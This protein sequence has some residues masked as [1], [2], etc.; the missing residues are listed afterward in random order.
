[1]C[2]MSRKKKDK[3]CVISRI[4]RNLVN[5]ISLLP[6]LKTLTLTILDTTQ[7][8][9]IPHKDSSSFQAVAN[10]MLR[11]NLTSDLQYNLNVKKML[12]LVMHSISFILLITDFLCNFLY[13]CALSWVFCRQY[14]IEAFLLSSVA[15]A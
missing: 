8:L 6:Q 4:I 10:K 13:F 1:M 3:I 7:R 2:L 5:I 14:S 9:W 12:P 11:T 15:A